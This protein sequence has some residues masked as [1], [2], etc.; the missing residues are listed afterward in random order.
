MSF[1]MPHLSSIV[2]TTPSVPLVGDRNPFQREFHILTKP[3][4][5]RK[6]GCNRPAVLFLP[7]LSLPCERVLNP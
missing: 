4:L 7:L 1:N 5:L 3:S 2:F 6:E